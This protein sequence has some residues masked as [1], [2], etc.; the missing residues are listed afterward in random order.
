MFEAALRGLLPQQHTQRIAAAPDGEGD[1]TQVVYARDPKLAAQLRVKGKFTPEFVSWAVQAV[2]GAKTR[3]AFVDV[4]GVIS[5]EN[6]RICSQADA[7]I[8]ISS[9]PDKAQEWAEFGR[10]LGLRVL[11]VLHSTLDTSQPEWFE[12]TTD[13]LWE[14]E[15]LV[16]GL[17]RQT[18]TG[19]ETIRQLAAYLME[20]VPVPPKEVRNT[21]LIEDLARLVGKPEPTRYEWETSDIPAL[22]KKLQEFS[23]LSCSWQVDGFARQFL[24]LT[25]VGALQPCAVALADDK[26]VTGEVALSQDKLPQ[27]AGYG[28][29]PWHVTRNFVGGTL[30]EY[31]R[32]TRVYLRAEQLSEV[33]PPAVARTKPVFLS[34]QSANWAVAEIA[35]AYFRSGVSAVYTYRPGTGFICVMTR[36]PRKHRLGSVIAADPPR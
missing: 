36:Q 6:R 2:R 26:V 35:L 4:G 18:Y 13:G 31:A 3:F 34:G 14:T 23:R 25:I 29:L 12:K 22:Y 10:E 17:D 27:G 15:G 8:I 20:I 30:V 33:I 1:W 11:A 9:K 7:L 16:V 19:S 24:A 21:I 5:P 28:P 32:D